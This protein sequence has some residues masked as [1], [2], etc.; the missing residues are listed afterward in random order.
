MC[1][2]IQAEDDEANTIK[3]K[4]LLI[5]NN[6]NYLKKKLKYIINSEKKKRFLQIKENK[7]VTEIKLN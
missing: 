2:L 5:F 4:E 1:P 3:L 6:Y 7:I